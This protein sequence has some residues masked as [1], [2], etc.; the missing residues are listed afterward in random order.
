M[1]INE[2]LKKFGEF[3]YDLRI[4]KE[5]TLREMCRRV[6]FD[7]SNWSKIERGKMSPPSDK[8]MLEL[9]AKTLGLK[10]DSQEFKE[11]IYQAEIAQGIIPFEIMEEKE[12][13]A[14]LPAFFRTLKNKKPSKEEISKIINM[15]KNA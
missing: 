3:L 12:L 8:K 11:F 15:V 7:P 9:W 10:K 1:K 4:K 6:N 14:A 13:V 2:S 5:I